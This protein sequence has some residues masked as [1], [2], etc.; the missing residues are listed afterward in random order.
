MKGLERYLGQI[1][2]GKYRIE[3]LLGKG[4]M[5]AVYMA[6]HLGTDRPVA[7]KIIAPEF[8]RHDEFVERFKREARAAG[9]LRHPNVVDVTDFGFAQHGSERVAYLVMEYLDGCTLADVLAEEKRLPLDWVADILEQVCSAVDEAHQQGI[10]HRDLKPD[11]IWLEPN[12]RGGY[13]IKVLDF[14]VAKLA[15]ESAAMRLPG[16]SATES[17]ASTVSGSPSA[18]PVARQVRPETSE[19][20]TLLDA[21]HSGEEAQTRIFDSTSVAKEIPEAEEVAAEAATQMLGPKESGG[22]EDGT[23]LVERETQ[24]E[25]LAHSTDASTD[26][27]TR[28]GSLLGT[29]LYMSPEQCRGEQLDARSDIY[30]LGVIAFQMLAGEVPFSGNLTTV[31]RLHKESP[32][33]SLREKNAKVPKKVERLLNSALA[34]D[35]A[36]RPASAAAFASAMRANTD[37]I[38]SLVRHSFALYSEH[39]PTFLKISLLAHAP[40]IVIE[41]LLFWNDVA[42][43]KRLGPPALLVSTTIILSLLTF[44]VNFL[45]HSVIVGMTVLIVMQLI[46]APLR[47]VKAREVFAVLKARWRPFLSTSI[48][49]TIR[50]LLGFALGA[51]LL[52]I[53]GLVMMIRYKLY[54]PFILGIVLACIPGLVIMI[55]YTL[56]VPVVLI[57]GLEKKAALKRARELMRRSR[58]TVI[59]VVLLQLS[60]PFLISTIVGRFAIASVRDRNSIAPKIYIRLAALL[61]IFVIPLISIMGALLYMKMRQIGG[62]PLTDILKHLETGDRPRSK[63]QQRMRARLSLSTRSGRHHS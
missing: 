44:V 17:R 45:T 11:N 22:G 5:G 39:F 23:L 47:P 55:R 34:K 12:R 62:E 6:I 49:V 48:R 46:I 8:M 9:R 3:K 38:G 24:R 57:E 60:I 29:P 26:G 14:G 30:S 58:L 18:Q 20:A 61:N 35:P 53:P 41:G 13:T 4:G 50:L 42:L 63:W 43:T 59:I 21:A 33:P 10:V 16:I 7:L 2:D 52:F 32:P 37:G 15:E 27:L 40:L 31:M 36:E 25:S 28:I 51:V 1:L 54:V 56:Y 19:A